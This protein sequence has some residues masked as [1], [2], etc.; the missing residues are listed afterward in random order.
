M[1]TSK[2]IKNMIWMEETRINT[3]TNEKEKKKTRNKRFS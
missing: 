1:S 3:Q 2:T